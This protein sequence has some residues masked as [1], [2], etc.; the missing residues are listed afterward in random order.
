MSILYNA[1]IYTLDGDFPTASAV[2][3]DHGRIIALGDDQ[4]ILANFRSHSETINL[5]ERTVI[6]GLI[7]SHIHLQ[8]YALSLQKIDCETK[9]REECLRR[10]ANQVQN[11]TDG[12][13]V[14]GHGWNQ[15]YWSEGFG[16]ATDLD[17]V[18]PNNPV[19][20]TSKSLHA[21]WANSAALMAAGINRNTPDPP[22]GEFQRDEHGNPTGI[23]FEGAMTLVS[24]QVP[25][26][27][28]NELTSLIKEAQKNLLKTGL[29]GIHDFDRRD[30]FVALQK[31][32]SEG[33]LQMRVLKNLPIEDLPYAVA[34]G[35]QSG[36]GDD[37]LRIGG[38]KAFA[39]GAL[40]PHT[41]AMLQPYENEPGNKGMLLMDAEEIFELGREA[42]NNGL[43]L[44][45][46]AIGDRANHEV[47]NAY[48]QLRQYEREN[49]L[50]NLRHRIEHVQ[51][52]HPQD[53]NRLADMYIIASMQPIHTT[54]DM[55]MADMF[56]GNRSSLAYALSTQLEHGAVL[57]FGSDA[58][59]ES[60]NPF[61]GLHAAVTRQRR[62]NTPG[63]EGWYPQERLTICEAILG[64]TQSAA[65]AAGMENKLGIL[66]PRYQADLLVLSED[67]FTCEPEEIHHIVPDAT[68]ISGEWVYGLENL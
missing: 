62:D 14:L 56:W 57:A 34:L 5:G 29:T 66:T 36:F 8:Q 9:E 47:L 43:S 63:P 32:H 20:L 58:P 6:P 46:H 50:Q 11:S 37:W 18:S 41:A 16:S 15:N 35:L 40:G 25:E 23:L 22:D 4:K 1:K 17:D 3:I 28:I 10:I 2:A 33:E 68:M 67:P 27:S 21:G 44:A 13:W 45:I 39:D 24:K 55:D 54:S 64:F 60:P 31:L 26:P 48:E 7:D 52:L 51:L 12:E 59:V 42:V 30:C 53:V 65:Y 49:N 38:I 61:W 19:Y